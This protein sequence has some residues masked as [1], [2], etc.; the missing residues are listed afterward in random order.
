MSIYIKEIS[1]KIIKMV[2]G[3]LH[4]QNLKII[5]KGNLKIIKYSKENI[6][7]KKVKIL[8]MVFF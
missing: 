4:L 3:I 7:G 5:S 8:M 6:Y 1:L 2:M